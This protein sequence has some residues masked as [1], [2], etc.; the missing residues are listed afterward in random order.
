MHS[1]RRYQLMVEGA[2]KLMYI[3]TNLRLLD[4]DST[5]SF[6]KRFPLWRELAEELESEPE[7]SEGQQEGNSSSDSS[8]A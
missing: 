6:H 1:R 5:D 2:F 8:K 7:D 4:K 3:F